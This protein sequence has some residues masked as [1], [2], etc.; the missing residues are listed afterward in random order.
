MSIVCEDTTY[1]AIFF[2]YGRQLSVTRPRLQSI[3]FDRVLDDVSFAT[4]VYVIGSNDCCD[5]LNLIDHFN[6]RV[7]IVFGGGREILW[8]GYV[9]SVEYSRSIVTIRVADNW[10]WAKTRLVRGYKTFTGD[11]GE[12]LETVYNESVGGVDAPDYTILRYASTQTGTF[13]IEDKPIKVWDAFNQ[14]LQQGLDITSY[15]DKLVIGINPFDPI[16]LTSEDIIGDYTI[17]KDG[18]TFA[19]RV[20]MDVDGSIQGVYPVALAGG[21]GYPLVETIIT[22]SSIKDQA[23]ADLAAKNRYDFSA[24]GV[25]RINTNGGLSFARNSSINPRRLMAGQLVNFLVD[26]LCF[27]VQETFRINKIGFTISSGRERIDFDM[28]PIG[29]IDTV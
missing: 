29:S 22:D 14:Y 20:I 3:T 23:T 17:V 18:E 9:L 6:T 11:V 1:D 10:Y 16:S 21:F 7:D 24:R 25:R 27:S 4:I 28:Q 5:D 15:A 13:E 26:D 19:N 12:F 2:K 8:R